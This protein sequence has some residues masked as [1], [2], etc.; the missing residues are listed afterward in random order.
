MAFLFSLL[1][2]SDQ[3]FASCLKCCLNDCP[4]ENTF[5]LETGNENLDPKFSLLPAFLNDFGQIKNCFNLVKRYSECDRCFCFIFASKTYYHLPEVCEVSEIK[6][7]QRFKIQ[8]V[9]H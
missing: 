1:S 3:G 5:K 4:N 7:N 9:S 2:E 6:W 8:L